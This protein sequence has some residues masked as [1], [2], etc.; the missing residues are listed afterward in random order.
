[1]DSMAPDLADGAA[2]CTVTR[3]VPRIRRHREGTPF[4]GS[5]FRGIPA[6]GYQKRRR[7]RSLENPGRRA[8]DRLLPAPRYAGFLPGGKSRA[9]SG[10]QR[11][12]EPA[13]ASHPPR[14]RSSTALDRG[15]ADLGSRTRT[16]PR[17]QQRRL[18]A[19]Q[20][21]V[22]RVGGRARR[23]RRDPGPGLCGGPGSP[24]RAGALPLAQSARGPRGRPL[25]RGD[26][27]RH[28]A[29]G[30]LGGGP[31]H[32]AGGGDGRRRA[33]PRRRSLARPRRP[34]PQPRTDRRQRRG[35]PGARGPRPLRPGLR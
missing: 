13:A 33:R 24:P 7:T 16:P 15:S 32:R 27:G 5:G 19:V 3:G 30:P 4:G 31:F 28:G 20:L 18:R 22:P 9:R 29:P 26:V 14:R 10:L 25:R 21:P 1:M 34:R 23:L 8:I 35:A 12:V 2:L 11:R 17:R 6:T